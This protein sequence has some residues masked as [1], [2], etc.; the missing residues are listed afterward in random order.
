MRR[1]LFYDPLLL[2]E[3]VGEWA[4]NRRRLRKL[5]RTVGSQLTLGHIDSL[6]L[7]EMLK[8]RSVN[9]V[10]D[11]GANTGTWT[12]LAKSVLPNCEVHAFE[13]MLSHIATFNAATS[14]LTSVVLHRI[15]LGELCGSASIRVSSLT[16]ASS[17]LPLSSLGQ[18]TWRI[19]EVGTES[20]TVDSID[21]LVRDQLV[22]Q[23]DLLKLDVQGFELFVLRGA[24][25]TLKNITAVI[26]EVSFTAFYEG[27]SLFHEV[28]SFMAEHQFRIEAFGNG[29]QLG[30]RVLQVDILFVNCR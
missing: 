24:E 28:A 15:A 16:D 18:E 1:Q 17:L 22:P 6:E 19:K 25:K 29:I 21:N 11:V 12:L 5:R 10:F 20:V 30:K 26:V 7:L 23:P 14:K 2:I 13:P 3:R 4:M 27:Q 8:T 9:V